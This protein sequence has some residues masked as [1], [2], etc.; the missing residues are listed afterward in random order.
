MWAVQNSD[1][2]SMMVLLDAGV[3]VYAKDLLGTT[4]EDLAREHNEEVCPIPPHADG[5][6]EFLK[7][8]LP[9]HYSA[10]PI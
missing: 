2:E 5:C 8:A 1:I 4:A 6:V 7:G 10:T 9:T 3:D